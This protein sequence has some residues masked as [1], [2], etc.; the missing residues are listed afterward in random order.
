MFG[1]WGGEGPRLTPCASCRVWLSLVWKD[2]RQGRQCGSRWGGEHPTFQEELGIPPIRA[3]VPRESWGCPGPVC[4]LLTCYPA[5]PRG[6]GLLHPASQLRAPLCWMGAAAQAG[7]PGNYVPLPDTSLR[8]LI[9]TP[10]PRAASPSPHHWVCLSPSSL[11]FS[12][13]LSLGLSVSCLPGGPVSAFCAHLSL[14]PQYPLPPFPIRPYP[15]WPAAPALAPSLFPSAQIP[16][17]LGTPAS[18]GGGLGGQLVPST[19]GLTRP[20]P[21]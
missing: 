7:A 19:P 2:A 14:S 15:G 9:P 5:S 18:V 12:R 20:P 21:A 6:W 13:S 10:F 17:S 8:D 16:P 1:E 11:C 4:P 3:Q